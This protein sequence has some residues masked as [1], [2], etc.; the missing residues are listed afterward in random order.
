MLQAAA[1]IWFSGSRFA[2]LIQVPSFKASKVPVFGASI[3]VLERGLTR[4]KG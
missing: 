4:A 1:W 3:T 2:A